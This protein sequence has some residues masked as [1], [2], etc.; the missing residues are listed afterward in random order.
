MSEPTA[1]PSGVPCWVDTLQPDPA[2]A[3]AFYGDVLGWT[4]AGPG[5]GGYHVAL[6]RERDV[7]GIAPQPDGGATTW[8]TYI[9]VDDVEASA[10]DVA[11]AGGTV[12]QPPCDA[13]PAGRFAICADPT[14]ATFGLWEPR[15]RHGAQLCNAPSAW[16]MSVLMTAEPQQAI[17]F[18][19]TVFGWETEAFGPATLFRRPGY[20]GGEPGQPVPRDVV[21]V[22]QPVERE[23]VPA[24]WN[25]GFWV[26][27]ADAVA[28]RTEE[29][30]GKIMAGPF[31]GPTGRGA[32]LAD[33]QGAH[34]SVSTAPG[35]H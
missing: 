19:N 17:D 27:D 9:S 18:Y 29:L 28:A 1:F 10:Q 21:A 7:A 26:D 12:V 5:P 24:H 22:L 35:P 30:G 8:N 2:A 6:T 15:A 16:A 32:V 13:P 20:F 11:A 14:G 3:R 33:P 23:G 4:Y 25:V 34:F 31:D